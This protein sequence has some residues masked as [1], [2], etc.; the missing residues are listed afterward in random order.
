MHCE[1]MIVTKKNKTGSLAKVSEACSPSRAQVR[2]NQQ[3]AELKPRGAFLILEVL[4][5]HQRQASAGRRGVE[6]RMGFRLT[7]THR[8][9]TPV[10]IAC[11]LT[12]RVN[13]NLWF[14]NWFS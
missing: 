13:R 6:E 8:L 2:S 1:E 4:S 12:F 11:A 9:E 5:V 7:C 3:A 10:F 14:L